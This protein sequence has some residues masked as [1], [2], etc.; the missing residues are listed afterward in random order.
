V[1]HGIDEASADAD[2][3]NADGSFQGA[4][5]PTV[6][7]AWDAGCCPLAVRAWGWSV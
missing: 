6:E 4:H 1:M 7:R 5:P 3:E 2:V